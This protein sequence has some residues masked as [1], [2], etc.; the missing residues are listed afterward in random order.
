MKLDL[1]DTKVHIATA[2]DSDQRYEYRTYIHIHTMW[3]Q[4]NMNGI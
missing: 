2:G 4:Y 1:L 3:I